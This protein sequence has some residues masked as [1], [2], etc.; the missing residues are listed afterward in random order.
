MP[1]IDEFLVDWTS[2]WKDRCAIMGLGVVTDSSPK[3]CVGV[4]NRELYSF[5]LKVNGLTLSFCTILKHAQ[6]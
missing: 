5:L 2:E 3:G 1:T 6:L 4:Y